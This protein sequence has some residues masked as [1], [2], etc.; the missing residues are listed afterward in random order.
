VEHPRRWQ[1]ARDDRKFRLRFDLEGGSLTRPPRGFPADH[2]LVE[3]LKRTDF[4][5]LEGLEE[6]DVLSAGFLRRVANAFA[7]SRP[8]MRFLCDA[9]KVPF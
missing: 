5:G 9:L 4:L 1:R 2:P 3:D 6:Q 8:L 7:A